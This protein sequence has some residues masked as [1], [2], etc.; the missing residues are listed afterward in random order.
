MI[1]PAD[2]LARPARIRADLCVVGAGPGGMAA[3]TVA[4]EAG[5]SVVVLEAGDLVTPAAST[6]REEDML[7][8]LLW[9]AGARTTSDRRV[10][11]VQGQGVGGSSLHNLNLCKRVPAPVLDAWRHERGLEHLPPETWAALYAETELLLG[12]ETIP[13]GGQNTSNQLLRRGTEALG[14]RGGPLQHNRAG[15]VGSGFCA[16]GCAYDAKNNALKVF[17]RRLV[18]ARGQIV[19]GCQAVRLR[20]GAGRVRGVDAVA[21]DPETRRPLGR[22]EVEAGAVCLAASATGTAALLRRSGVPDPGGETGRRLHLHPGAVVVGDFEQPVRAWEGIPQSYECTEWL[23]FNRPDRRAWIATAF[24]DPASAAAMV[25]GH[26]ARHRDWMTRYA[27]LAGFSVMLHDE[28]RGVVEPDGD[29]DLR[30]DYRPSRDDR[31]Q[32]ARGL[33]AA[34]RL[35]FAAG[36]RRVL[37]PSRPPRV[38]QRADEVGDAEA[39]ALGGGRL[40]LTAVHPM[41]TVPMGD[42]PRLAAVDSAGRH[43][44]ME[45]LWVS[46]ASLFPGSIGVPPQLSVYALGLHVGRA[47]VARRGG[48]RS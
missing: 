10:R 1:Y 5:L 30:I 6:Q 43:H 47:L 25:P 16:L 40:E 9:H 34:A 38:V 28:T 18:H 20:A 8:R 48:T 24:A 32:L 14:W 29:L 11:V 13:A 7:P 26:G 41:G 17:A 3:A 35:L 39:E 27:H 33:R 37:V 31:A 42:D 21:L 23:D 2:R 19:T 45:G 12:V 4:A 46:D 44:H 36:A 22:L 15:C